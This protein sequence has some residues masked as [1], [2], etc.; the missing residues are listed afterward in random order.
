MGTYCVSFT[1]E[2]N[3]AQTASQATAESADFGVVSVIT[4]PHGWCGGEQG[5]L[6]VVI[7]GQ[8]GL[9]KNLS[10]TLTIP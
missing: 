4:R 9:R 5:T 2:L 6:T 8:D 7:R 3:L 10:F 1:K